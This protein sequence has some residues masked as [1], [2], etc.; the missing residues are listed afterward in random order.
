M[1]RS[2]FIVGGAVV[3]GLGLAAGTI[4]L[5]TSGDDESSS[6]DGDDYEIEEDEDPEEIPS[7][8]EKEVVEEKPATPTKS[9]RKRKPAK[10]RSRSVNIKEAEM[11]QAAKRLKRTFDPFDKAR[12]T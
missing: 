3:A 6:E 1:W 8:E 11:R 2:V 9:R 12:K 7:P 4:A 10:K 5:L